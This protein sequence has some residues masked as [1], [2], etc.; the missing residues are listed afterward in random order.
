MCQPRQ[1]GTGMTSGRETMPWHLYFG[2]RTPVG[3]GR[4]G[5]TKRAML[6]VQGRGAAGLPCTVC[7]QLATWIQIQRCTRER[8][9]GLGSGRSREVRGNLLFLLKLP[10]CVL[11]TS[12]LWGEGRLGVSASLVMTWALILSALHWPQQGTVTQGTTHLGLWQQVC[13]QLCRDSVVDFNYFQRIQW[14][15]R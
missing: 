4:P 11:I 15:W 7:V 1:T 5:Q 9:N 8:M 14:N 10:S 3:N 2:E 13:S 12:S 6:T